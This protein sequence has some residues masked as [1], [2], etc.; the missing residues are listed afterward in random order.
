[1]LIAYLN[2]VASEV[3]ASFGPLFNPALSE[4]VKKA[5]QDK[6]YTKFAYLENNV[7]NDGRKRINGGDQFT[8]V[9]SYLYITLTWAP[10]TGVT[11]EKYPKLAAYFEGIKALP[12][13]QEAHKKMA[14][15]PHAA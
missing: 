7:F 13:V 9:D 4:E 3:H 2:Y 10:Y 5:A 1:M 6:L 15:L 8:I 14:E 12:V 11:L